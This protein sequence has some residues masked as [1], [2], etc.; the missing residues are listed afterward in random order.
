MKYSTYC[1]KIK[2]ISPYLTPWQSDT[3]YGHIFWAISLLEG[4]EEVSKIIK[5][6]EDKNPPFIISN[7]L[8]ENSFPLLQKDNIEREFTNECMKYFKENRIF[9]VVQKLKKINKISSVS[10]EE[11]NSLRASLSNKDFIKNILWQRVSKDENKDNIKNVE[12]SMTQ[13]YHNIINRLSGST[14]ENGIFVQKEYI[15]EKNICIYIKIREDYPLEKLDKYLKWI[16]ENGYGK[17]VSSGKGQIKRISFDKFDKFVEIKDANAFVVLSNY[18]PAE[19]DYKKVHHLE[20]LTKIPKLASDYTDNSVIFK[21]TFS[22]F[23]VGS[24]FKTNNPE[25]EVVGKVLRDIH[26]DKKIVQVGIPFILGVKLD[27]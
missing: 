12:I 9:K 24:I 11:F 5:D 10:L 6:F 23:T 18:I 17:K 21:K 4:E 14:G 15:S 27:D 7:G 22:C 1:W 8:V 2:T 19:D 20:I 25:K 13:T 3:I 16:E 26:I